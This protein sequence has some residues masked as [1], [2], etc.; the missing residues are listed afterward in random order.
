[1]DMMTTRPFCC[2]VD[3][4]RTLALTNGW[5]KSEGDKGNV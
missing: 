2:V 5:G 4:R 3:H 1:M